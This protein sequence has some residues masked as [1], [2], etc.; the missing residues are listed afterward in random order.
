MSEQGKPEP[1]KTSIEEEV[2]PTEGGEKKLTKKEER[3]LKRQQE[4]EAKGKFEIVSDPEAANFGEFERIQSKFKTTRKFY[5]LSQIPD[6]KA[7]EKVWIRVSAQKIQALGKSV[8]LTLRESNV[9]LQ[10]VLFQSDETPKP[11]IKFVSQIPSESIIDIF[12]TLGTPETPIKDCSI[13]DLEIKVEKLFLITKAMALPLQ[14]ES[15]GTPYYEEKDEVATVDSKTG[16]PKAGMDTRL[17][18]RWVDLRH[19]LGQSIMRV[20]N[21]VSHL[22]RTHLINKGFTEIFTPKIIGGTSEGGSEIFRLSYFGNDACLAQSPQLYKQVACACSGFQRVFEVGPVFRA[23]RSNTHRHLCEFTGLDFEMTFIEHYHEVLDEFSELFIAIFKGLKEMCGK[24][25]ETIHKYHNFEDLEFLEPSLRITYAEGIKLIQEA[26]IPEISEIK[27][28]DDLKTRHEQEL[29]KIIKKKYHTDFFMMDKYPLCLRPFYTMPD[30]ENPELSNSYD[31]FIRGEEILSGAQRV[32]DPVLLAE[33]IKAMN[34][35]T[36]GLQWYIDAF[37]M[38][39]FPHGGGGI[40]LGRVVM[41][42]LG[43]PNIR[44]AT[45]FPRDPKRLMP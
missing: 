23:E 43:L 29:G 32:H 19:P 2:L 36:S 13:S 44:Q 38:G 4:S 6:H 16:I 35:P 34:I 42:F 21:A 30:P 17:N 9:T 37:K 11:M 27:F 10:G 40:G 8:F 20:S 15:C 5:R 18:Y 14:L 3:M 22:F 28:G 33:R 1:P 45:W 24:D 26:N 12:G 7:G 41:L 39:A 31:F 25:I